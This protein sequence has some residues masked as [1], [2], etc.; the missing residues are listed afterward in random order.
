MPQIQFL[1]IKD[2]RLDLH[3]YRTVAQESEIKALHALVSI[4]PD[5]FWALAQSLLEDKFHLNQNIVVL[6]SGKGGKDLIVREGNRRIG[7]LK[8]IHGQ[9]PS[10]DLKIPAHVEKLIAGVTVEWKKDTLKVPCAVY[11][12]SEAKAVDKIVAQT[13]GKAEEAARVPWNAV[14][15]ARHNRDENK[16]SEPG[17]DLLEA[18]LKHGKNVTAYQKERWGGVYPLSVLDEA[19]PTIAKRLGFATSREVADKYPG[20]EAHRD[21]VENVLHAI[22]SEQLAFPGLRSGTDVL[23][24]YG[25]PPGATGTSSTTGT[26]SSGGAGGGSTS[27]AGAGT[28]GATGTTG[29]TAGGASAGTASGGTAGRSAATRRSGT[30]A[31]ASNDPRAV[32]RALRRFQVVGKDREKVVVLLDEIK[33]L[34]L[35]KHPHAFCFL[36]RSM[37]EISAKAYCKNQGKSA[38]LKT[39][40]KDGRDR[41][42]VDVLRDVTKHLVDKDPAMKRAL[43]GAMTELAVPTGFLSVTS[44]NQLVHDTRFV[45]G[46]HQIAILFANVFPLLEAMNS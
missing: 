39:Q 21:A 16:A 11:E 27:A 17:L 42:L 1:E 43:H 9:L 15:R 45:I 2:L 22:G 24:G 4:N 33:L 8:L 46:P 40:E 32:A 26:A 28:A 23:A 36:L 44:M 31:V 10:K 30:R 19:L 12:P 35:K 5:K 20:L 25:L 29:T 14:A 34:K 3:N 6:K 7:I 13:H 38:A 37:F 41:R 18:Y